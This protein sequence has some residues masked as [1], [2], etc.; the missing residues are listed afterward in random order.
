MSVAELEVRK[1]PLSIIKF[2]DTNPNRLSK[3]Q[4]ESLKLVMQKYGYLAPVIL[5][6][7]FT[8][9]DGEHR[10]KIYQELGKNEIPAYV[11]DVDDID[12]KILRQLMNK[13]RGEHDKQKDALEFKLIFESDRLD[14][15]SKLI[16]QPREDF[17][18]ILANKFQIGFEKDEKPLELP[19]EVKSKT[20][21]IFQLGRHKIM[22]GDCTKKEDYD[23]LL[24]NKSIDL[25]LTDPPYGLNIV[26]G[27]RVD[28]TANCGFVG[29]N[30]VAKARIYRNIVGDDKPFDPSFLL[31]CGKIKIIFGANNFSSKLPDSASWLVW[32][33]K[34]SS[35]GGL[36]HNH[37]SDVE[38]AWTNKKNKSSLIYRH[39][40]SGMLRAGVRE[41][42]LE[43]RVH[44][45][46]KPVGLLAQ[47][48]KDHTKEFDMTY[49]PFLGSGSTLIACEQTNRICYGMEI[50]PF[51][52]DVIIQ[53]WENYTGK[54]AVKISSS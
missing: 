20:G 1:I 54:K 51:Y 3:E 21:D 48:I 30:S 16:A 53:R 18:R 8:I 44:P 49:D 22:C 25:L 9:I 5:N 29:T 17:E 37:F 42:E 38:L 11:I 46:Q 40:W 39:L 28:R 50:D 43:E 52:I 47:I 35:G 15:F 7:D 36:D 32:D 6:K 41:I 10:V 24:E 33:K 4:L 34:I 45:T 13:L 23:S 12:H 14:E 19:K 31:N 27:G 26:H 2:D